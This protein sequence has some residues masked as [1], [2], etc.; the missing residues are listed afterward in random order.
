MPNVYYTDNNS[1]TSTDMT[2]GN[3]GGAV[4]ENIL[5]NCASAAVNITL[6]DAS[7]YP[8]RMIK[9]KKVDATPNPVLVSAPSG[10]TVDGS[11]TQ[12]VLPQWSVASFLSAES[13]GVYNW[14]SLAGSF[15]ETRRLTSV[16]IP[17][18]TATTG[19]FFTVPPQLSN[20]LLINRLEFE[21]IT[22]MSGVLKVSTLKIGTAANTYNEVLGSG[23][24]VFSVALGASLLPT[25]GVY[26]PFKLILSTVS[27]A[28]KLRFLPGAVLLWSVAGLSVLST[29]SVRANLYGTLN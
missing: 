29:G 26:D 15:G 8:G 19:N 4:A 25:G 27:D 10:Q 7:L 6:P 12:A 22:G 5:V 3:E 14:Y 9:V 17:L 28:P 21:G 13:G 2:L 1:I 24:Q 20:G 16:T 11:Q 18:T 23:G